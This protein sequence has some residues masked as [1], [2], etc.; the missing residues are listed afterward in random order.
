VRCSTGGLPN[1]RQHKLDGAGPI[2][3]KP[4]VN[5][6][7]KMSD[8]IDKN[9]DFLLEE[10]PD[11]QQKDETTNETP[12]QKAAKEKA[13]KITAKHEERKTALG[14][15]FEKNPVLKMRGTAEMQIDALEKAG[16]K[17]RTHSKTG[18]VSFFNE[19]GNPLHVETTLRDFYRA[20][21]IWADD[22]SF[23]ERQAEA[24]GALKDLG[25]ER[26][27]D[28]QG[29]FTQTPVTL[30][31]EFADFN[32]DATYGT[33]VEN[34]VRAKMISKFFDKDEQPSADPL[35]DQEFRQ[36]ILNSGVNRGGTLVS[37]VHAAFVRGEEAR[38]IKS[39][40]PETLQ[41]LMDTNEYQSKS[42]RFKSEMVNRFGG[43]KVDSMQTQGQINRAKAQG[44]THG[45][46]KT[47]ASGLDPR[48]TDQWDD[49][50]IKQ[51]WDPESAKRMAV[52]DR[53][54]GRRVKSNF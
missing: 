45:A 12:E 32:P 41:K 29:R 27:R 53:N 10:D 7:G 46:P 24:D 48:A 16:I 47:R 20:N 21:A 17:V 23:H 26:N 4:A 6:Q 39:M 33:E 54:R 14:K 19:K 22:E 30:R 15:F 18:A 2:E 5:T 40:T 13:A 51:G 37:D 49:Y 44:E 35:V 50:Y 8:E 1:S 43:E 9:L 31:G 28:E 52:Y 11:E 38:L 3:T 42:R 34:K 36:L 25:I